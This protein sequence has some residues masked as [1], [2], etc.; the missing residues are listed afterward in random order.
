[1]TRALVKRRRKNRMADI[2]TVLLNLTLFGN[3]CVTCINLSIALEMP[4]RRQ[5]QTLTD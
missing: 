2:C 4:K 1:M 5:S 3:K